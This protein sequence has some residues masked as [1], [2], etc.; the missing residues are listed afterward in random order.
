MANN[1]VVYGV[2]ILAEL[3]K[4]IIYFPL[5]WYTQGLVLFS[6]SLIDFLKNKQKS[7]GLLVWV[8]NIFKPMYGQQDWQGALISFFMR[9]IQIIF[10]G[11]L[12]LF[13]AVIS[14]IAFCA[15]IVLPVFVIYQIIYQMI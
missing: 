7:L 4:D 11:I 3:I 2:K 1:F 12:M 15:W 5:W 9:V 14:I 6:E 8:K 13:F 10:R